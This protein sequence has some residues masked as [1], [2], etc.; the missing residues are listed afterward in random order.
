MGYPNRYTG[1]F[2]LC[3]CFY[4]QAGFSQNL[5]QVEL[6][7][8]R[9][10]IPIDIDSGLNHIRV[11]GLQ[12]G[13]SY[14]AVAAQATPGQE[15][16]IQMQLADPAL[17]TAAKQQSRPDRPEHR[18]FVATDTCMEL[19]VFVETKT[20][21]AKLPIILSV[22]CTDCAEATVFLE[23]FARQLESMG[24]ANLSVSGGIAANTLIRNTLIG[25]DCFDVAN[26]SSTGPTYSRGT[27]S[28]GSASI[29]LE[30]G[31][32]LCTGSVINLPGPNTSN[33]TS[34]NGAGF[35][36][37][38]NPDDPDLAT[39]TDGNQ[40]DLSTIEF[41]F[42]P[43]ANAVQFDYVFG[44]E[45][46]CEFANTTYNDVFGFFISGPGI[47]GTQ[48][49]AL[50][51]STTT[52]V[53][54][55]NVNH[56]NNTAY[57]VNNTTDVICQTGVPCCTNDCSLD[58]WTTPLTATLTNLTPCSTYHIKLAIAD[59]TDGLLFS[60]VFLKAN[61]FDAGGSISAIAAYPNGQPVSIEGCENGVIRFVRSSGDLNTPLTVHYS[62]GG[63][64][65]PGADYAVLPDSVVIPAGDSIF[66]L[67]VTVFN[68][69]IVEGQE[70]IVLT[71]DNACSCQTTDLTFIIEDKPPLAVD[72]ADLNIC[73]DTST[74]LSPAITAT[75]VAPLHYLWDTG[76]TT[77]MLTITAL[78]TTSYSVTVTDA[79]GETATASATVTL[80]PAPVAVLS[81][82]GSLCAG[83]PDTV[84]LSISMSGPGPW[85]ITLDSNG[86]TL[87]RQFNSS[88]A[89]FSVADP[90]NYAL[91]SV[92]TAAG[93]PGTASGIV[94]IA[95]IT[96]DL[97][98]LPSDPLCFGA[99]NGMVTASASGGTGPFLYA[100]NT[101]TDNPT[102]TGLGPGL[103]TVTATN[104][105]GCSASA[106]VSLNEPPALTAEIVDSSG[107]DCNNPTGSAD[108]T[109][110]GGTPGFLFIWSNS[111]TAEDPVF[112]AGGLYTVTV[113][114][115]NGCTT[116]TS[117]TIFQDT[118][119]PTVAVAMPDPLTCDSLEVTIDAGASAQGPAF[120]YSWDGPGIICCANTLAPRVD[121]P[122]TY[123][124]TVTNSDNGC[125]STA[126]V[127]IVE[128]NAPP[129][130]V[131]NPPQILSCDLPD[132]PL[133]GSGSASGPE[134]TFTWSTADGHFGCCQNTL[135]PQVDLA[136]TYTL[137]V[138]NTNTGCSASTSVTVSGNSTP[139][140]AVIAP[141]G[142]IDCGNL[143]LQ[144]DG[145]GST[146]GSTISYQWVAMNGGNILSGQGSPTP[147]IDQGGDYSLIVLN[148]E[149]NCMDTA[150]VTVIA[151]LVPPVAMAAATG[152]LT[153]QSPSITLDGSGSSSGPAITYQWS[154]LD[155]NLVSGETGLNP[156]V[157]QG[158]TYTILVTNT[159][160]SCTDTA[161]VSVAGNQDQPI[162]NA[163]PALMLNC[164]QAQVQLQG[165]GSVGPDFTIQWTANPGFII[166]G[167][168]TYNPTVNA[169][170]TYTIVV[171]NTAN[172]CSSEDVVQI[173]ANF[174]TPA[175]SI[176]PPAVINCANPEIELDA[177]NS[178][179]GNGII[180][181]W[182]TLNGNIVSGGA[183]PNPTVDAPGQYV[184]VLSNSLSGCADTAMVTVLHDLSVPLA[185]A[186][187]GDTLRCTPPQLNL[188]GSGS[189][190]PDFA[191]V[192]LT[193]D[194]N[195]VSGANT[196]N[197][198]I[199]AAGTYTL[200]VTDTTN[201]CTA[202][203][204]VTIA[205][206]QNIP[207]AFAGDDAVL[208][209]F[210]PNVQLNGTGSTAGAGISYQWT[211]NPGNIISGASSLTPLVDAE[212]FYT[213]VVTNNANGCTASD[214]VSVG[215]NIVYPTANIAPPPEINCSNS[216]VQLDAGSSTLGNT[217]DFFWSSPDG[218]ISSGNGTPFP[219]VNQPGTYL[220]FLQNLENG[221]ADSA[222]VVV[223]E[224]VI[225]PMAV[226]DSVAVLTCQETQIS[227][228][229]QGSSSGPNIEYAWTTAGGNILSGQQTLNPVVDQPGSYTLTVFNLENGCTAQAV[230]Q[231]GSEQQLPAA[232][233]GA[234][235]TITCTAPEV[236]LNGNNSAQGA[237]YSYL[238]T[239]PDGNILSGAGSLTPLVDAAGTYTLLVTNMETGCTSEA[240][241]SVGANI[242]VP[243]ATSAPGGILS[244][245]LSSL[246][247]DGTGSSTGITI[248]YLWTSNSGNIVSGQTTLN[249]TVNAVGVYT[250]LVTDTLNG[251]TASA[252]AQVT[253]DASLPIANA[254]PPDT[255]N[256]L[257]SEIMLDGAASSQGGQY[258]Y[259]WSGPGIV[260]GDTTLT[261]TI[262]LP[263]AY[264]LLITDTANGCTASSG[265]TIPE[266]RIAPLVMAGP[267]DLLTCVDTVLML[268]GSASGDG[269]PLL[270]SWSSNTGV[271]ILTG[272][273]TLT[274]EVDQ[275]GM[276]TLTVTN[277]YNGCTATDQVEIAQD[278]I[279]PAANAGA[280][281]LLTCAVQHTMLN[282]A[283]SSGPPFELLWTTANGNIT[284]GAETLFPTVDAPGT[285]LLLVT[286]TENGCTA[287]A[288]VDVVQ[289]ME[290]PSGII[291]LP[292]TLGCVINQITLNTAGSSTGPEYVYNWTTPDGN[293]L[294]GAGSPTPT[295]NQPGTYI[296]ILA[297][298]TNG[299]S[300]TVSTLVLQDITPPIA[301][302]GN[303]D[304]LTCVEP[305]LQLNGMGS[306][307]GASFIYQWSTAGGNIVS[308]ANT[309]APLVNAPGLYSLLVT[310]QS[311]GCT[312][313]ASVQISQNTNAL[314]SVIATPAIL[315]CN[316]TTLVLNGLGSSSGLGIGYQ[317]NTTDG[318]IQSG[319]NSLQPTVSAPGNYT[320]LVTD[321]LTGCTAT[322]TTAVQQDTVAPAV[323]AGI[324]GAITCADT[325]LNLNGSGSGGSLGI[326]YSWSTANGSILSG[327][328]TA[329]PAIN[330]GGTYTL[331]VYDLYNG[332]SST[333]QVVV[334]ADTLPP[335]I[336]I[337]TPDSLT[338]TQSA[339]I[340]DA[341]GS[342]QGNMFSYSWSGPGL[343]SGSSGLSP[344][345]NLPGNYQI[346]ITNQ[347]T[348]CT[349]S[350]SVLIIENVQPPIATAG[351]GFELNCTVEDG[352]LSAAGSSAGPLFT[353]AW[354]TSAGN[355][356][357]GVNTAMPIVNAA[358]TY[359]LLV[360]NLQ[361][362][363]TATDA[364]VVL[365]NT[366]YPSGMDILTDPPGC[367]GQTGRIRI[368]TV[369]GGTGPYL[370]SIDG[371]KTFLTT[372][373]FDDLSPGLYQLTVQDMHGCEYSDAVYLPPPVIPAI[374]LGADI[375]LEFGDSVKLT[376]LFNIP[377]Y[378]V[379]TI[380]W[381]PQEGLTFTSN[382]AV[383]Y[384]KPFVTTAYT[385]FIKNKD[386]CVAEAS[387]RI[388][389]NQPNIWA[390]NAIS[391]N[392]EDG[393]NDVFLIFAGKNAVRQIKTLQIFDRWG[394][395]VFQNQNF[396][397]NDEKQGWD[398][399][400]RGKPMNPAVFVWWA[401]M[402]LTDGQNLHLKGDLT[403][404]K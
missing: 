244:C 172:G 28:N 31:I 43:T 48:N 379:D 307:T 229:G 57:Y 120:S 209:C 117:V 397:P 327:S 12:P 75:G 178:T 290:A 226:A 365:E 330:S 128:D 16:T 253:A 214:E 302:A 37:N 324:S 14:A 363:C 280:S 112:N 202:E 50:L 111:D 402:E 30:N 25:G 275:P 72:M 121:A 293:I 298:T 62:I 390:P 292:P 305:E 345:V 347:T 230:V 98:L 100:W 337:A 131:I 267:D 227:L 258:S 285:Y 38:T 208:D 399:Y 94:S 231:V 274:P 288:A 146:T 196:L 211:A 339:I 315:T 240:S 95:E 311:N 164:T 391:P 162:A 316:V 388:L 271:G 140:E 260:S 299:C 185:D 321:S 63:T 161:S 310:N 378:T 360:T 102:I 340:I 24:M 27:F 350:A 194:G 60:A 54:I 251:C 147:V 99:A 259:T 182:S 166:N 105:E 103:F 246:A 52:P 15:M 78:G 87:T 142:K 200:I 362:G 6:T 189:S 369:L 93:C 59:I 22:G 404:V 118:L 262:N 232:D 152:T 165:S 56:V 163:G 313:E 357:S 395:L 18:M 296:L 252:T 153:C 197:P 348:G 308:G 179:Q 355:I 403:I 389:V 137:Q 386:G 335:L 301:V 46:Y 32:V 90:G 5:I 266:D 243:V 317:W 234:A 159:A 3:C 97:A 269:A 396:Q 73:G 221:C 383:V 238:W 177:G 314:T 89:T 225:P 88:P 104:S 364:V 257:V 273:N 148:S 158:G 349:A 83:V 10:R 171:T 156:V 276:Y 306:S 82:A 101:G 114:D 110:G 144:L 368:D 224:N 255:L 361:N 286:N 278:T 351:N 23:K 217:M 4:F 134:Y 268:A 1:C 160:N 334:P 79:C 186:G 329:T 81:G 344:L 398:G 35:N 382:P 352:L 236:S 346:S 205:A 265:V 367:D 122:G 132:L 107:I 401:E 29:G 129:L 201:G 154:T 235:Q 174:D 256:C 68:D 76:D 170:G 183:T 371:G 85:T 207:L 58:G 281:A 176:A 157:N 264:V 400:F 2:L 279:A 149:N 108:L 245:T 9:Q 295:V 300:D 77:A 309:L 239:T 353:Y 393:F 212:G 184:L 106:S 155:G 193:A 216:T 322:T 127:L 198:V 133:D 332:C 138:T 65:T 34:A 92:V 359:T 303:A 394:N 248:T 126:S 366:E 247:L 199:D 86:T 338:C 143:S 7:N 123:T 375:A 392:Q 124:L 215:N 115:A 39:L 287:T 19:L 125:T 130:V 206:D 213:L 354:S 135:Q 282:G 384:A 191:Y 220:L 283:G 66:L 84:E 175:A 341:T 36:L 11:C 113:S 41:D 381:S 250:L 61:S 20:Q 222:S 195:I 284:A 192:W 145:S 181:T 44:S 109:A 33:S 136:G 190:G 291:G 294:S 228:N 331:A 74:V 139:P 42:T 387:I 91:T 210:N 385:V 263:G 203:S 249:P 70:F 67:P 319:A 55:N 180:F 358:G 47:A 17:E 169:A 342:V 141:P 328:N 13:T 318:L 49:L 312:G 297:D 272:A 218:N 326:G 26:V 320:L 150:T 168:D 8:Q 370:Y 96:V 188:S 254:G 223:V 325:L 233:A 21:T 242:S 377:P 237:P 356:V 204:M 64:A 376:A 372:N 323:D 69:L 219:Q 270:Y 80:E 343:V 373:I 336:G 333:D 167:D 241:V 119:P 40:W 116:I 187:P 289:D 261:P 374:N 380:I 71:L 151:D 45:E 53:T 277:N 173:S 51:P 304:T